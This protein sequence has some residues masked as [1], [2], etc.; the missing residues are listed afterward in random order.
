ME[1]PKEGRIEIKR[2]RRGSRPRRAENSEKRRET[3]VRV[4]RL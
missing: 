1:G 3:L 2:R 4:D